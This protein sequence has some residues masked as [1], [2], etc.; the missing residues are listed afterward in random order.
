MIEEK[1]LS[2]YLD[3]LPAVYRQEAAGGRPD[4]LGRLLLAFEH[5]LTGVGDP[6]HAGLEEIL[7]GIFDAN[8]GVVMAGAH[9]YFVPGPTAPE[10]ERAPAEFLEWLSGWV[11]L[12]LRED[13]REEERRRILAE[14]VPSYRRRGTP[15]GLK[16]VLAAF[17]GV[18]PN[19]ITVTEEDGDGDWPP[20]YFQVRVKVPGVLDLA[21]WRGVL[22]PIIDMEKPAHTYYDLHLSPS[23]TMQVGVTSTV[24]EDTLLGAPED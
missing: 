2:R 22:E 14:I 19:A 1:T 16:Q 7:D 23:A 3:D 13:W 8:G 18:S 6:L 11:A 9:S 12:T 24:G 21:R 5:V 20:H 17:T 15:D 10:L 4:F